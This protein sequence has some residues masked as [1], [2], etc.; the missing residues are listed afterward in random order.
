[1]LQAIQ[2]QS[3][4]GINDPTIYCQVSFVS[5][6]FWRGTSHLGD[7]FFHVSNHKENLEILHG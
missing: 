1:M 3:L 5:I 2:Q 7:C 4:A 6:C